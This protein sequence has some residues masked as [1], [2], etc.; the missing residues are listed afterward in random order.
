MEDNQ[1]KLAVIRELNDRFRKS[2]PM[3]SIIPGRLVMTSGIQE[4]TNDPA[5]PGKQLGELFK[6]IRE[7]DAF[8]NAN[9]PYGEH[10]FGALEF[11]GQK[12]FWKLDYYAPDMMHGAEDPADAKNT[13]RVLT[14]MLAQEY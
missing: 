1:L 3:G 10:D 7:F 6:A 8:D 9:D 12:V 5:E 11:R 4:L 14:I 13:M 2:I